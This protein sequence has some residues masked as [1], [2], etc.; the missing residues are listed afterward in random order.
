RGG[1]RGRQLSRGPCNA[2]ACV[3]KAYLVQQVGRK[4]VLIVRGERPGARLLRSN[5]NGASGRR[6]TAVRKRRDRKRMISEIRQASERLVAT[7]SKLVIETHIAL[8]LVVD[9]VGRPAVII[10]GTRRRRQRVSLQQRQRDRIHL[11]LRNGVVR[12]GRPRRS[13]GCRRIVN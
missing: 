9:F 1:S 6:S 5:R 11:T 12:E 10:R 2:A 8:F 4:G 13:D 3:S 7:R